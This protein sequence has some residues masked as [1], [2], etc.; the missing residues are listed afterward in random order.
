MIAN[1]KR[2]DGSSLLG[3][4]K[5]TPLA[6]RDSGFNPV[7]YV[8]VTDSKPVPRRLVVVRDNC[9]QCHLDIGNPA[10]LAVHGGNRRSTEYCVLCHNP[11]LSDADNHP[12]DKGAPTPL[13]WKYLIHRIHTGEDGSNPYLL[14]GSNGQ[15][16][17]LGDVRFPGNRADC[18]K[19]HDKNTY[20]LPLPKT[21][22]PWTATTKGQVVSSIG[23]I[24]A[25]CTACHDSTAVRGHASIMTAADKT[26]TCTVCHGEGADFAVSKVHK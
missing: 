20:L 8:A 4:D 9:N 10:G 17:N 11:T 3:P 24:T 5:K 7:T 22:L 16:T 12:A 1:L 15:A 6:V 14:Y 23:P 25:A 2:A 26:E 19:C 21:A 13:Q 18:V